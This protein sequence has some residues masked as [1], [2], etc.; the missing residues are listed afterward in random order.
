LIQLEEFDEVYKFAY[1]DDQFKSIFSDR[2]AFWDAELEQELSPVL[3][4]L[5]Q[6]GEVL[7]D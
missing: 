2:N 7:I 4:T 1:F 3:E 6:Y 5:K